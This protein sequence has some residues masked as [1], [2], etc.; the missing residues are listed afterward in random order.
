MRLIIF[1]FFPLFFQGQ[2]LTIGSWK[3]HLSYKSASFISEFNDEI[4][5]INSN[6]L[7]HINK[8]DNSIHR[9]SKSTGLSDVKVKLINHS[10]D[11]ETTIIAYKNCN[12][13]IIKNNRIINLSD[14]YRKEIVGDK[15]INNITI[16]GNTAYLSCSFGL[17]LVDLEKIEIKD[18]YI[19]I[20]NDASVSITDC[21]FL[22]DSIIVATEIGLYYANQFASNLSDYNNWSLFNDSCYKN[23][24]I[25]NNNLIVDCNNEVIDIVS[26]E[27]SLIKIKNNKVSVIKHN[28]ETELSHE[29]FVSLKYA[30]NE[31]NSLWIADSINGLLKFTNNEYQDSFNPE[32]PISNDIYSLD[33]V[34]NKLFICHGGHINFGTNFLNKTGVSIMKNNYSWANENYYDLGWSWDILDVAVHDDKEYYASWYDGVSVLDGKKEA[35]NYRF[36][37]KYEYEN[38]NGAL[39][40]AYYSNNR[41]R[42]S[43]L[44]IDNQG[45]LWG[46]NSEVNNPLFVK[47]TNNEW[48]SFSMN[49]QIIDLFFDDL[50]IDSWGQKWGVIGRGGG[51]FVYNDNNTIDVI[52][53]DQYKIL[54]TNIG[55][56]NLPS[57]NVYC[58]VEDLNNN[59]WIGTDKGVAVIYNPSGVFSNNDY[60]AQQILIQEGN[61]GQ[62]LLSEELITSIT[63]D[64]ANRKWIG[65]ENSGIYLLSEDGLE[66][67]QHFTKENSP[68]LSNNI[69]DIVIDHITGEVFIGTDYGLVSYRSDATSGEIN[70]GEVVVFP[71]PV[72][73]SYFGPI[74]ISGLVNNANIK[75]TDVSGN[76]VF[77]DFAKGG[78]AVWHG[79]NYA[80][81][82]VSS[83]IY[84]VFCTDENGVE[85]TVTKILFI[86]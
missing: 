2:N 44:E 33:F 11:L 80:G 40:T 54:S 19:I 78:Q 47:T 17:V 39:D 15:K 85:K 9:L 13:D 49:Q 65:T 53:D 26:N 82:R 67:I 31:N 10:E 45:N 86:K 70:Q 60:D 37:S 20:E 68:L 75:I 16:N 77:E 29:K 5:C 76:L 14:I 62:Y 66:E 8:E 55:D 48:Y 61:Y 7:F 6:S 83:G 41:I 27:N 34:K 36:L 25:Y 81:E 32:G 56:G 79:E 43:N 21:C 30:W 4:Y 71:N 74:A 38:T 28:Q 22:G 50:I 1:L 3:S 58:I 59:V 23:I 35:G 24:A 73:E 64:G 12:L 69:I 18:T 46:L 63:V 51:L 84:L 57:K 72:R 52:G 42:I